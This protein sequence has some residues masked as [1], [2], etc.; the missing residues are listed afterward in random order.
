MSKL[1]CPFHDLDEK[2]NTVHCPFETASD[3]EYLKH[4]PIHKPAVMKPEDRLWKC[5]LKLAQSYA[6]LTGEKTPRKYAEKCWINK[7][8]N[9]LCGSF[10]AMLQDQGVTDEDNFAGLDAGAAAELSAA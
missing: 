9:A 5:R 1:K 10:Q 3:A 7:P 4:T 2:M 6:G 8:K